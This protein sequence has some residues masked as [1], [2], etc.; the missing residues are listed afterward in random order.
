[1]CACVC[2]CVCACVCVY[3]CL[4]VH[5][6]VH[7]HIRQLKKLVVM[8]VDK[9]KQLFAAQLVDTVLEVCGSCFVG[10]LWDRLGVKFTHA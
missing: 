7:I 1:M 8:L 5:V 10:W 4:C 3:M 2:V 6:H 9:V